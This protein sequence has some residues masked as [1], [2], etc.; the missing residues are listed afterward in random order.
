MAITGTKIASTG[1]NKNYFINECSI[2]DVEVMDSQY[3]DMS[4]KVVLT[5]KNNGYTY[6]CF[7][8]QNFEKDNNGVVTGLQ[9]P[10]DL[11]TLFLATGAD[12][13]VSD[14]G[15]L[16]T[17]SLE[18]LLEKEVACITYQSTGKYKRNTWGVVSSIKDAKSLENRFKAQLE[19]GYPKDY[20]K[21]ERGLS[22]EMVKAVEE[23]LIDDVKA[24][25]GLPF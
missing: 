7:V 14:A 23:T 25:D 17:K 16:D 6:N 21:P 13:N 2:T 20:K 10:E 5:D 22:P 9:F 1:G 11:N 18:S 12:L 15:I 4:L 24:E 19:K 8:N 3:T